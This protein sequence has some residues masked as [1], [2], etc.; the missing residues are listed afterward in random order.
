M[1]EVCAGAAGWW[2]SALR[3]AAES[4]PCAP[5]VESGP[6]EGGGRESG[7]GEVEWF[8]EGLV[9]GGTGSFEE[10]WGRSITED[11]ASG[12]DHGGGG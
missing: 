12:R 2:W 10:A 4:S 5:E 7:G 6:C 1:A 11:F 9:E 3:A 8:A